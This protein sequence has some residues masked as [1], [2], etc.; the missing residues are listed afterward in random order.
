MLKPAS[1]SKLFSWELWG[2]GLGASGKPEF[3]MSGSISRLLKNFV[4]N[5]PFSALK[6]YLMQVSREQVR[7]TWI[8]FSHFLSKGKCL[9]PEWS[10]CGFSWALCHFLWGNS[11]HACCKGLT[12]VKCLAQGLAHLPNGPVHTGGILVLLLLLC[13]RAG[14]KLMCKCSID[15]TA[16]MFWLS[17]EP[18][19]KKGENCLNYWNTLIHKLT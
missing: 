7:K 10:A 8:L 11:E 5:P 2:R 12:H 1:S 16:N 13:L 19:Q 17:D 14:F 15:P 4:F 3:G 9:Y 6:H 18:T